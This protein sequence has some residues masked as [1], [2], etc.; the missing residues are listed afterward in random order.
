MEYA[1]ALGA[2]RML[3]PEFADISE[4]DVTAWFALC[5][6]LVSAKRFGKLHPQALALLA[7]H[8]MKLA[9]AGPAA[10]S[11]IGAIAVAAR[12][13]GLASVS[14][15]EVSASFSSSQSGELALTQYGAQYGDL[16][17][18]ATVSIISAGEAHGS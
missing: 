8:R 17:R 14:E 7:A 18:R 13:A 16:C 5:A 11:D 15:G 10:Q 9:G 12:A 4:A 6:P 3:A 1:P 2:F